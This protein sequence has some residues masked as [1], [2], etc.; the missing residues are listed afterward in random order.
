MFKFILVLN[1]L[2]FGLVSF[3]AQ[4]LDW[5]RRANTETKP[6]AQQVPRDASL[7][8]TRSQQPT[9]KGRKNMVISSPK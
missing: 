6:A 4:V 7:A 1:T 2:H 9:F 5:R 8:A 3:T